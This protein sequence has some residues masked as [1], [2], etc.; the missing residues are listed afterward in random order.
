MSDN[1]RRFQRIEFN[2]RIELRLG[3]PAQPD[4]YPGILRD[5]S[6]KGAL[7]VLGDTGH[8]PG[9]NGTG[10]LVVQLDQSD[11]VLTMEV[12]VSYY[13][14]ERHACGLNILSMDV[15]TAS[16][17]RRLVEVNL[18]DDAALQRELSNLIEV[19]EAEHG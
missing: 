12:E 17:L 15:D 8:I 3:D 9:V 5:I 4:L 1:H 7:V 13:H 18:G 11:V 2:A 19:M 14:A 6:L 10:Q 16:H